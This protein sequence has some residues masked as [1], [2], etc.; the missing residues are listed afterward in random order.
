MNASTKVYR[1][2]VYEYE[3]ILTRTHKASSGYTLQHILVAERALG[4]RLPKGA[5]VHHING[6]KTDNRSCNLVICENAAYHKLL[7]ARIRVLENGGDPSTERI[8]SSCK[9]VLHKNQ[10]HKGSE[11][12]GIDHKC[13]KC[14]CLYKRTIRRR[15]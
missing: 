14:S 3:P 13:K 5:Q 1:G 12:D 10:F 7:H 15:N 6:I 8:C 2:Y 9:M 4:K 11:I